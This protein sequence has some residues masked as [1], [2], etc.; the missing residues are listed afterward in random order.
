[1][2]SNSEGGFNN[3]D[4]HWLV[5]GLTIH[6]H[7]W[8]LLCCVSCFCGKFDWNGAILN[9]SEIIHILTDSKLLKNCAFTY[10][11]A[12][13]YTSSQQGNIITIES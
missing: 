3:V 11:E 6:I 1:M 8:L 5:Q 9:K 4:I 2:I 12:F 10:T 13:K 7:K